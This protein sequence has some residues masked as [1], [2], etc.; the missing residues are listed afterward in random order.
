[1]P[2]SYPLAAF[3]FAYFAYAGALV[4]Y[5]PAYFAWRGLHAAEIAFILALPQFARIFA[6]A[7]WGAIADRSGAPRGIVM[8]ACGITAAAF[9]LMPFAA[10]AVDVALVIALMSV[11]NAGALPLVEAI[12]LGSLAAQGGGNAGRYG[13][14]RLWGSVG[15]VLTVLAGGVWLDVFSAGS[16]P[17][18]LAVLAIFS[19]VAAHRL[20]TAAVSASPR[21]ESVRLGRRAWLLLGAGFCMA[22]AHGTLYA[23]LTLHLQGL[24]YSGTLIGTLWTLGVLAEIVVFAYLPDIFRRYALSA[25]IAASFVCAIV[26]FL[27]LGWAAGMLWVAAL[28][29]LLHGG[30]FGAFHAASVAAVQR[31]FPDS[32]HARGQALFSGLAYGA[33]GAV[34]ALAAGWAWEAAGPG[35]SFSLSALFGLAGL[36][37]AYPLKR[38]GL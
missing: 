35:P 21:L 17:G 15:F 38:A 14:I 25:V 13:P 5:L 23:F 10:G 32:A 4:A 6:P 31:V 27:A 3:Y 11:L 34:G 12:T 18:V 9:A 30:T 28:A 19:L 16:L 24:G 29:Q 36:L 26:R 33:G 7:A 37:L 22:A 8:L 20:P 1:M 2:L